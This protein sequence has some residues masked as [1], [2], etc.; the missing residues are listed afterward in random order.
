MQSSMYQKVV[1]WAPDVPF[2]ADRE[3]AA[4]AKAAKPSHV[5]MNVPS[6]TETYFLVGS[7]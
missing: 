3:E 7:L 5:A 4:A 6:P 1:C 2:R